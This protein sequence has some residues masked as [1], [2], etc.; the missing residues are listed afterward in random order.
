MPVPIT[1]EQLQTIVQKAVEGASAPPIYLHPVIIA[2]VIAAVAAVVTSL[3]ALRAARVSSET[4]RRNA[5]IQG[6]IAQRMKRADFRQAWINELR[7]DFSKVISHFLREEIS[8][9]FHVIAANT[10]LMLNRSDPDFEE[11][12]RSA[13]EIYSSIEKTGDAPTEK[14]GSL[15]TVA[16]RILKREWE[17]TKQEIGLLSEDIR[18]MP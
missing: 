4:A 10:L 6:I 7:K 12:R 16:Q 15:M 17:V 9:E 5:L 3:V 14:I 1:H 11:Y 13:S 2:A 8:D 18:T